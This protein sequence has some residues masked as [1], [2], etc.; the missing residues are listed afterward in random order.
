MRMIRS[1]RL[2]QTNIDQAGNTSPPPRWYP[3]S[4][5]FGSDRHLA[6]RL[7]A[8]LLIPVIVL[9]AQPGAAWA[10]APSTASYSL[11]L[12]T[13]N[14]PAT[15]C[16]VATVAGTF[17]GTDQRLITSVQITPQTAAV[18]GIQLQSCSNGAWT[19]TWTNTGGWP[20]GQANGVG[21]ASVI[22]T[23]V[24]LSRLSGKGPIR[25]GVSSAAGAL[26]DALLTTSAG[27]PILIQAASR[28]PAP[29]P[30]PALGPLGITLLA[31]MVIALAW[32]RGMRSSTLLV[33][34][35]AVT[36][37]TLTWAAFM[38]D[39]QTT[40][41]T[42][43]APLATQTSSVPAPA[44]LAAL[45]ARA[46]GRD[47]NLRIDAVMAFTPPTPNQAPTVDAGT[48]QTVTLPAAANLSASV[49]DD[50]LPDPPG[51]V[52]L[53][54]VKLSGPG[55]VAFGN[56][57]AASTTVTFSVAGV[58]QLR[59]TANDGALQ[60]SDTLQVTVN[61]AF[62]SGLPP[63]PATVAPPLDRT[64]ATSLYAATQF[65]YTGDNPIQTGVAPGTIDP[66]RAA[67]IRGRVLDPQ[68]N[69][70]SGVTLSI[71]Q[72]PEFGQ[73]LSRADGAFDLVV[74]GGGY[75]AVNYRKA[76][77]LPA[78]RQLNV[79]WQD[80]V[81][82]PDVALIMLDSRVTQIDLGSSAPFQIAQGSQVSDANG[83]REGAL[84]VPAGTA[85]ELILP[86][87]TRQALA[88]MQVRITEYTIGEGGPAAMPAELPPTSGY[89]YAM[90]LSVDEAI[91]AGATRVELDRPIPFYVENFR[92]FPIGIQVPTAFYDDTKA[93]WV[94]IDDGRVIQILAISDGAAQVDSTGDGLADNGVALGMTL[95]ERRVLASR[96]AVGTSL[97]RVAVTHF[98]P[99]DC[100]FG[101]VLA[102]GA[103][104][105]Q[106]PEPETDQ[107]EDDPCTGRGSII[108]CE[109]QTLGERLALVGTD[110]GLNYRSDR[111]DGRLAAYEMRIPVSGDSIPGPLKRIELQVMI[112]GRLF[113]ETLPAAPNQTYL[114]SWDG[115]DAYGR[116]LL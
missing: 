9:F 18:D 80:S 14:D 55:T 34:F 49:T 8:A 21:G 25:A 41:W 44:G 99:Y 78:Q 46:E 95:D 98:T 42:G 59:L 72:H 61:P 77:H 16:N 94:P 48:D 40:D 74:N 103:E 31:L 47:L 57:N 115:L 76:S 102:E 10:Q 64:V 86:D 75:L 87:G 66:K 51:A 88:T 52:T 114:F 62:D 13:D 50:G 69:P 28:P 19:T 33:T 23:Y 11:L 89:T 116:R 100:N 101:V 93:A 29:A 22:E 36:V 60:T 53:S 1:A 6:I 82:A 106:N 17:A 85:A 32:R 3:P 45:F 56:A 108:E 97:Q 39:G 5:P 65:L 30:I 91:A 24:P 67:V 84:L 105:P 7:L 43:I 83:T 35:L 63:D 113:T 79:P 104:M 68:G 110:Q 54:W 111:V 2:R 112:A 27:N 81:I 37:S 92:G 15:G 109:N 96:Y 12:D 38:R 90:E 4:I 20:V 58:Y 70:L 73:T 71:N 26:G 107:P